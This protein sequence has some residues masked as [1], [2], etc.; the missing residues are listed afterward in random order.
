MKSKSDIVHITS[1]LREYCAVRKRAEDK[2]FDEREKL[3]WSTRKGCQVDDMEF[4]KIDDELTTVLNDINT[5]FIIRDPT[6][7]VQML[8]STYRVY[9]QTNRS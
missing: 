9:R 6:L 7:T 1:M 4:A 3:W 8:D 2:W 5:S